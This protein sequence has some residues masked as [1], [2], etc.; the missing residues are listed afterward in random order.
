[1]KMFSGIVVAG[2]VA[3]STASGALAANEQVKADAARANSACAV[4]A[5][6][7]GCPGAV[8][9]KGL[10]K[11]LTSHAKANKSFKPAEGCRSAL[12]QLQSDRKAAKK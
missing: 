10:V 1:M 2:V 4:D 9:G 8:V 6:T 5:Q 11:C 3:L 7:A 12:K